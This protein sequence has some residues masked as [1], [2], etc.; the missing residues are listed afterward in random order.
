[1]MI[2][3]LSVAMLNV[4]WYWC[5]NEYSIINSN[6]YYMTADC[7]HSLRCYG[8]NLFLDESFTCETAVLPE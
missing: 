2:K 8:P 6:A 1:M 3:Y 4:W 5:K 7:D